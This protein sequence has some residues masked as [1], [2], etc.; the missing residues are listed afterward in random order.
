[1]HIGVI[2]KFV[3]YVIL[4][5][6]SCTKPPKDILLATWL[7]SVQLYEKYGYLDYY[8]WPII[9]IIVSK[10]KLD[11]FWLQYYNKILVI[12][13]IHTPSVIYYTWV[14]RLTYTDFDLANYYSSIIRSIYASLPVRKTKSKHSHVGMKYTSYS[15]LDDNTSVSSLVNWAF[16]L[17][18]ANP[19]AVF[20]PTSS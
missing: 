20:V 15:L 13:V 19:G 3:T 14:S 2:F 5:G 18:S 11:K 8:L 10:F 7:T 12:Y 6:V 17:F 16:L 9:G 1:M 4:G